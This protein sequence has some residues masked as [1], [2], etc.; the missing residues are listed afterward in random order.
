VEILAVNLVVDGRTAIVLV[1]VVLMAGL[2]LVRRSASRRAK[3]PVVGLVG[4]RVV[5]RV[6]RVRVVTVAIMLQ[7]GVAELFRARAG[8][9]LALL[10]LAPESVTRIQDSNRVGVA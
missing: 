4:V 9:T 2:G 5:V 10:L 1:L 7:A 3:D 6:A 8:E